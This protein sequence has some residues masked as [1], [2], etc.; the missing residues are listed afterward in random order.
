MNEIP[1][2]S[3]ECTTHLTMG[4]CDRGTPGCAKQHTSELVKRLRKQAV[5]VHL[6][7]EAGPAADIA[8]GL[9][10]AAERIELLEARLAAIRTE[11]KRF[12][13]ND[14]ADNPHY[15]VMVG[16]AE[17]LLRR[18]VEIVDPPYFI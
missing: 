8:D 6:T 5:C 17:A 15:I 7:A 14:K 1:K 16:D 11:V 3:D 2:K 4:V 12:S 18:I 10:K 13:N 9:T